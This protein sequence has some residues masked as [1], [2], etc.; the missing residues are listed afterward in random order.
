MNSNQ[1]EHIQSPAIGNNGE[2][3]R[4]TS[5]PS[6]MPVTVYL[7]FVKSATRS[8]SLL[9]QLDLEIPSYHFPQNVCA[10]HKYVGMPREKLIDKMPEHFALTTELDGMSVVYLVDLVAEEYFVFRKFWTLG[11][12]WEWIP[13]S[14]IEAVTRMVGYHGVSQL[15][16]ILASRTVS[17][18]EDDGPEIT[19]VNASR[20]ARGRPSMPVPKIIRLNDVRTIGRGGRGGPTGKGPRLN[21]SLEIPSFTR[22][23]KNPIMRGANAGKTEIAVSGHVRG[24]GLPPKPRTA[25]Y[26]QHRVVP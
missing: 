16:E 26:M 14:Y 18:I 12:A 22:R 13:N 25:E 5:L 15:L 10:D 24:R 3:E 4:R 19:R 7:D 2:V 17:Y 23:Y 1:R 8:I 11:L 9:R 6:G 20:M 21:Y